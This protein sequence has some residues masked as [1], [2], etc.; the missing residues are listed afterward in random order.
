MERKIKIKTEKIEVFAQLN[1]SEIAQLVWEL[2]PF[3]ASVNT[4][5][6]EIYFSIPITTKLKNPVDIV[7]KGDLGYWQE[8][9]CFCIFFGPTPI[10]SK[11]EI[12]PASSVEVIGKVIGNLKEFKNVHPEE[13]ITLEKL[14]GE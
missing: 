14:E 4:W 10:S 13:T 9:K 12:K 2:L 6:D 11:N 1:D 7:E 3:S 8:G 5:G